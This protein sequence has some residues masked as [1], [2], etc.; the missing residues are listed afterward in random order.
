MNQWIVTHTYQKMSASR[1]WDV[2]SKID[3]GI[4]PDWSI[5]MLANIALHF[6]LYIIYERKR[7]GVQYFLLE[8]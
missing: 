7:E 2:Q 5:S 1:N 3:Q 4:K 6:R 8:N